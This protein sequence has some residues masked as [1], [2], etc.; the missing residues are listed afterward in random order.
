MMKVG[1][2]ILYFSFIKKKKENSFASLTLHPRDGL[3][4]I[5]PS[6]NLEM[7][8][9]WI[10]TKELNG[11][12]EE[13]SRDLERI[14]AFSS[15]T[16]NNYRKIRERRFMSGDVRI[17]SELLTNFLEKEFVDQKKMFQAVCNQFQFEFLLMYD[18]SRE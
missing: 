2:V 14:K 5:A 13:I 11:R 1:F 18:L 12:V 10:F 8:R 7:R 9:F 3:P 17:F 15:F 6:I 4:Q 16:I